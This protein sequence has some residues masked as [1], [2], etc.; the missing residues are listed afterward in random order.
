VRIDQQARVEHQF[1]VPAIEINVDS[2]RP[3]AALDRKHKGAGRPHAYATIN[4]HP[5]L[6]LP[7][8]QTEN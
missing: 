3:R 6:S 8:N 2:Y 5:A 7:D 4:D 1:C